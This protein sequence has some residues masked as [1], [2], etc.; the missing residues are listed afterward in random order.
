MKK[1]TKILTQGEY[2]MAIG[3]TLIIAGLFNSPV[4]TTGVG[5]ILSF[6]GLHKASRK[7]RR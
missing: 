3:L 6:W 2:Y 1:Q 4:I 7:V 5:V